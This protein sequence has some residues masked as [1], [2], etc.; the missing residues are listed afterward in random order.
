MSSPST[1]NTK[2]FSLVELLTVV[3]IMG[4]LMTAV[5]PAFRNIS[6]SNSLVNGANI[7][8]GLMNQ[9]RVYA[10]ANNTQTAVYLCTDW[11]GRPDDASRV[12]AVWY[13]DANSAAWKALTKWERLPT[14]I[15]VQDVVPSGSTSGGG[16]Y[17]VVDSANLANSKGVAVSG[18]TAQVLE[19]RFNSLGAAIVDS[20]APAAATPLKQLQMRLIPGVASG[21]T[22]QSTAK[23]NW[24][25]VFTDGLTGRVRFAQR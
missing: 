19:I 9:A 3:A 24:I 21:G 10:I 2:A 8:S 23:E 4:L 7:L 20:T 1:S 12:A 5:A 17:F 6:S 18:G 13:W 22:V 25:D 15:I 16:E 14:G 11:P